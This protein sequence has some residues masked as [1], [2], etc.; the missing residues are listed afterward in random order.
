MRFS[1]VSLRT[2]VAASTFL[3]ACAAGIAQQPPWRA[4]LEQ[5]VQR[6]ASQ[7]QADLMAVTPENWDAMRQQWRAELQEMLGL[8]PFPE[9]T[10]LNAKIVESFQHDGLTIQ[11]L[12]F[13][14]RP[15]LYVA[16]NLYLPKGA[17]P[18]TGWPAVLYVCGHANIL[19]QGR[20]LGNKTSYQHHGL[21]F[22]RHDTVC[23]IIDTIQLGELHGEHHGTYKLGR[24][25]WI[26]RGYTPAGV[27]AWNA[28]RAVDYLQS[29]KQVDPQKIGI[30][31]RSGGGAYS[32]F[33]AALDERIRAAVPVAGIT[34]LQDHVINGCVEGHCDCMYFVNY[35]RWDYPKL[36]ALIAP[37]ALLLANSDSDGIFPLDGVIRTHQQLRSVYQS[38]KAADKYG[39]LITPGPHKDTQELQV[40]AFRWL[41]KHLTGNEPIVDSAALKEIDHSRLATFS[42]EAPADERVT[43]AA[44]WFVDA[45]QTLTDPAKAAQ[46]WRSQRRAVIARYVPLAD[47]LRE[48][49]SGLNT[50]LEGQQGAWKWR[51]RELQ[52]ADQ[53]K[54]KLLEIESTLASEGPG[55]IVHVGA[56][57]G[58]D[59]ADAA[60]INKEL[61][62]G[63]LLRRIAKLPATRHAILLPRGC[64]ASSW[65]SNVRGQT[66]IMRRFYLLGQSIEGLQLID[67]LRLSKA[68]ATE[69]SITSRNWEIA[70][71]DRLAPLAAIAALEVAELSAAS[72]P[73]FAALHVSNYPSD[74]LL[75]ACLPGIL[76]A[77]DFPSLLA[78]AKGTLKV[79]EVRTTDTTSSSLLVDSSPEPQQCMG[80]RMVEVRHDQA[81]V[82]ARAT[83]WPL[84]N[85]GDLPVIRFKK[86]ADTGARNNSGAIL[87]EN[88]VAGLRFA[89]PGVLADM[90]LRYRQV[91]SNPWR[92][93][94]WVRVD[95]Q[96]DYSCLLLLKELTPDTEYELR[97]EAR[98]P[99]ANTVSTTQTGQLRTNAAP[100]QRKPLRLAVG[101]CQEFNDRDGPHGFDVYRT[102]LDR[103]TD[104]Y[105]LAGDVV[106]YDALARSIDLAN[107]HWQRTYSLP[108]LVNFH[109]QV[110]TYFLKD[111]HD[112]YVNDS[113][114]GKYFQW[115]DDFR[116]EDGQRI[117]REQTALPEPAYRTVQMGKDLQLWMLEGRD[118]RSP[119]P[120]PDTPAKSVLGAEQ[121]R[122]LEQSLRSSNA[123]FRVIVSPTPIVG[124]DR[125]NKHDNLSNDNF[126]NEGREIRKLL[127]SIPNT[128]VVCGDRHWQ[129]H[130]IDPETKLHEFSVGP[131]S[132][133]HAGGWKQEDYRSE[134][135]QYLRVAGG[136]LELNLTYSADSSELAVIHLDPYG[137]EHHRHVLK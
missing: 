83:R 55:M 114:P 93:S 42:Q 12:H 85:L 18:Q 13:Q 110:P 120:D 68:I 130:S 76:R 8:S 101:T 132:N 71:Y 119:N 107:Y 51:L 64:D 91:G 81:I 82:W 94:D 31:G 5:E 116:F 97:I 29:L 43:G 98:A 99:Q 52:S 66:Q 123:K 79:N 78:A 84:P 17:A 33:T 133:R 77:S 28:I 25:D 60:S 9:R 39:V 46:N 111:D 49:T 124:P 65:S 6:I 87:P 58:S 88:G 74:P 90:R 105:I 73:K 135:H 34:D 61:D 121:K 41:L 54:P 11:R 1:S 131:V 47:Q 30:T 36:A 7:S 10:D 40:G 112:T 21:W 127:A 86:S 50:L 3:V 125:E 89:V 57:S 16:A 63:N 115:T 106:Y 122:W 48:P 53:W 44:N 134:I 96:T 103:E 136:Y 26:S 113:W 126:T 118:H 70:G 35:H 80:F 109:K 24:W 128:I 23:L 14:S 20:L 45:A 72:V 67:I 137:K 108:T 37:R 27:E 92:E 56:V 38:L 129:Y 100:D 117:F 102:M 95:H 62:S 59:V 75:A 2:I 69:A 22:A 4:Y 104:A 19:H 15:G 32:W